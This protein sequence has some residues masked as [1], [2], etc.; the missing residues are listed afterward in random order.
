MIKIDIK[1][2][3]L[4]GSCQPLTLSSP[5]LLLLFCL[6]KH[7]KCFPTCDIDF[8]QARP[9]SNGVGG[10]TDVGASHTVGDR[11]FKVDGVVL[12]FHAP[13][14]SPVWPRGNKDHG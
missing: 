10:L 4:T 5:H 1:E 11:S 14:Q 8:H 6:S 2:M 13:W 12:D 3:Q 9:C 7:T